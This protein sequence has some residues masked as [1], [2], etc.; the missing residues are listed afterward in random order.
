MLSL[1]CRIILFFTVL[2]SLPLSAQAQGTPTPPA[3]AG[4]SASGVEDTLRP[5]ISVKD[6]LKPVIA[7]KDT[8]PPVISWKQKV[9]ASTAKAV[10][11]EVKAKLGSQAAAKL[12]KAKSL[13]AFRRL[14]GATAKKCAACTE[15]KSLQAKL[16][17]ENK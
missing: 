12:E 7:V 11:A 16:R 2:I 9:S 14:L 1:S 8:L 13:K 4:G 3:K 6:S 17:R 5:V 10:I 15:V